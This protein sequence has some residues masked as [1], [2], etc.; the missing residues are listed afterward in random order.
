VCV[1]VC[2]RARARARA[3]ARMYVWVWVCVCVCVG[4]RVGVC[5]CMCV[6]LD[7]CVH[8]CMCAQAQGSA[9]HVFGHVDG[10]SRTKISTKKCYPP[11]SS[12]TENWDFLVTRG[13]NSNGNLV[14]FESVLRNLFHL[15]EFLR[16]IISSGNCHMCG[17]RTISMF[18]KMSE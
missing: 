1:C 18:N 11:N 16:V 14:P 10:C 17:V 13:T 12:E 3:H 6:C 15:D 8:V 9:V 4:V 5:V 7:V 2:A